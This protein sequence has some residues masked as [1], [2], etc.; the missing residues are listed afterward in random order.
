M[1]I[2]KVISAIF[3]LYCPNVIWSQTTGKIVDTKHQPVEGAT[4]V[5]Q[6]P[7]STYLEA[8]I[9]AVDGT[10]RLEPEPE[11]YQLIVQHLLYQTKQVKGQARDAGIITLEP[12]DYNL[13]G[14]VIEGERPFV[15]V[16]KGKLNYDISTLTEKH[17]VNNAYEAICKLPGV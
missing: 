10:F 5:M 2:R 14:V 13:E 16:E 4:I 12:K 1:N 7:D 9:S 11:K 8:A 6:L 17:I 15:T 3:V